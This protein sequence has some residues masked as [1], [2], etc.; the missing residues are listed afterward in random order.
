M[1][2]K[3]MSSVCGGIRDSKH[4]SDPIAWADFFGRKEIVR[5]F[6]SHT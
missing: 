6:E 2:Q 4:D 3:T 5:I 1:V